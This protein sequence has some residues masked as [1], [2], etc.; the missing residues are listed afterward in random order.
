MSRSELNEVSEN[1]ERDLK[2][3]CRQAV[4]RAESSITREE[5]KDGSGERKF[6]DQGTRVCSNFFLLL[7]LC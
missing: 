2:E 3:R 4:E 5:G 7:C 1:R 6:K